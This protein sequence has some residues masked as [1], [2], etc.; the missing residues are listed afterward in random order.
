MRH[1]KKMAPTDNVNTFHQTSLLNIESNLDRVG[2]LSPTHGQRSLARR[3]SSFPPSSPNLVRTRLIERRRKDP[4][5]LVPHIQVS[6]GEGTG[7]I[8]LRKLT[9]AELEKIAFDN[10]YLVP[11]VVLSYIIIYSY[12]ITYYHTEVYYH[13]LYKHVARIRATSPFVLI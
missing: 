1:L 4:P 8:L 11:H 10:N 9:K 2:L 3:R 12:I 6:E 13:I 5:T 7:I